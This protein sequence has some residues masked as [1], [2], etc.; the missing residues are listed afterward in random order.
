MPSHPMMNSL[1]I[2][3]LAKANP[4][5]SASWVEPRSGFR[6]CVKR[7]GKV[8]IATQHLQ[9]I[10]VRKIWV[11]Q[12]RSWFGKIWEET[13]SPLA[14]AAEFAAVG[15]IQADSRWDCVPR[16]LMVWSSKSTRGFCFETGGCRRA[17]SARSNGIVKPISG[18]LCTL[19][20][21]KLTTIRK[22]QVT[23]T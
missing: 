22:L 12:S 6:G 10:S 21:S 13:S 4:V 2:C 19:T 7:E 8:P 14:F 3:L 23:P 5:G 17:T 11:M 20:S 15:Q 1:F 9:P 16:C 18:F